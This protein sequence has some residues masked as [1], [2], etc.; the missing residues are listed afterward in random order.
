MKIAVTADLHL[1]QKSET[2][3]R[4]NALSDIISTINSY[5]INNLIIAGDLFDKESLNYADF[6]K[7][8]MQ[9]QI[10]SKN[11]N[12][13]IIPG[14][15][16]PS[17]RQGHF[18][19]ENIKVIEHPDLLILKNTGNS[20]T[21]DKAENQKMINET[22]KSADKKSADKK[23]KL[24][25]LFIPYSASKSI[26]DVLAESR[27]KIQ[28]LMEPYIIVGHGDYI[29]GLKTPNPYEPGI[30]M[31]LTR[32]DVEFYKPQRVFLG[33]IHKKLS[34]G[35]VHYPGSPCGLD[36]NETG[37]RSFLI[38][39][40]ENLDVS[41]HEVSTDVIFINETIIALPSL[42]ERNYIR[43]KIRQIFKKYSIDTHDIL[44]VRIRLKVKGYTE[45][46]KNL[47]EIIKSELSKGF[48]GFSY[49]KNEEP[50]LTDVNIINDPERISILERLKERIDNPEIAQFFLD[51]GNEQDSIGEISVF[52]DNVIEKALHLIFKQ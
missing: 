37:K 14:N 34:L 32:K 33:H 40:S 5:G 30:Y 11:I 52:K 8:C 50:D 24:N 26:G 19:I 43:D 1:K 18:T 22:D 15:H 3:E 2:P 12:F 17:I 42:N 35:K 44:R 13:Y 48:E 23:H 39:D 49:Y 46:K 16:D 51:S 31:P 36:I 21:D 29:A 9:E 4:Y 27:E 20:G 45:D 47:L 41:G 28:A 25:V 6:E 10:R 38:I 7:F